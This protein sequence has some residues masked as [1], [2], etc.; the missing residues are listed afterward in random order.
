MK[1][2]KKFLLGLLALILVF[3]IIGF[4]LPSHCRIEKNLVMNTSPE[5]V[6]ARV[7]TLKRWPE[8]TAWTTNRFPDMKIKFEGPESGVG[9]MMIA[10]GKSSGNGMVK[11]TRAESTKGIWYDLDFEHGRQIFQGAIILEPTETGLKAT[12]SLETDMG[13]NPVKRWAGLFLNKLMGGDMA[14]GLANLKKQVE[15]SNEGR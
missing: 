7:D 11:I 6:F 9:A 3:L 1:R 5:A 12:W 14:R 15:S 10:K 8:W 13:A 4:F 2:W